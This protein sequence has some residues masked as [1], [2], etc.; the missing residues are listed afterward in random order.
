[1]FVSRKHCYKTKL[2]IIFSDDIRS[3]S[4]VSGDNNGTIYINPS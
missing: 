1:M 3:H 2:G 4:I